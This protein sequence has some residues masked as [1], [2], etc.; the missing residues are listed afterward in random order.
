LLQ[1]TAAAV[2]AVGKVVKPIQNLENVCLG[3]REDSSVLKLEMERLLGNLLAIEGLMHFGQCSFPWKTC[4]SGLNITEKHKE[5]MKY[6]NFQLD[7][8]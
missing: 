3:M 1:E 2:G 4:V 6:N 5:S 8:L 7:I